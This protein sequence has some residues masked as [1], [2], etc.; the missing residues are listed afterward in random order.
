V[1]FL[2]DMGISPLTAACLRETGHE[3]VHL[4]QEQLDKLPDP[5]VLSKARDEAAVLVAHDLDFP[6]LL[7]A[8]GAK[9]PSVVLLRLRNMR[10]ENVN[11]HLRLV[12]DHYEPAL[13]EGAI[14]TVTEGRIRQR[15]LPIE[16]P[17]S[18]PDL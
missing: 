18:N 3:A 5:D 12:L 6:D 10:P 17:R 15:L 7:A 14:L 4:H 9:L 8:S 11:R 2:L 16:K 13:R 1:K